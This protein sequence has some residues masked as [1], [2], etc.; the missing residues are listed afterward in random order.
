MPLALR[1]WR[2]ARN[3]Q[4]FFASKQSSVGI[5][6]CGNQAL[7]LQRREVLESRFEKIA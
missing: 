1:Y 3:F 2:A 4:S 7:P 5:A 6:T